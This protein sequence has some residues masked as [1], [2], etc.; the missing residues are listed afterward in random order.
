MESNGQAISKTG[1]R[2]VLNSELASHVEQRAAIISD[3]LEQL[4]EQGG[5]VAWKEMERRRA[6]IVSDNDLLVSQG[7]FNTA[8]GWQTLPPL[9]TTQAIHAP[10]FTLALQENLRRFEATQLCVANAD[11]V[12]AALAVG[13]AC[14]LNF[15]NETTPGGLYRRGA[16]A[17]EE[18]L[19]QQIPQLCSALEAVQHTAYPIE[20]GTA[21]LTLGLPVVRRGGTYELCASLGEVNIISAAMPCQDP[22]SDIAPD[23]ED[24]VTL[25]IR[26]VLRA[27]LRSGKPNLILGA[28]GCGMFGNPP[29]SVAKIFEQQLSSAEFRGAFGAVVFAILEPSSRDGPDPNFEAFAAM[30]EALARREDEGRA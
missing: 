1:H 23:W 3:E 26:S 19:C 24:T 10:D 8:D 20:P 28:F 4:F 13:D 12:S 27:G 6:R 15:A 22:A 17:Q 18:A 16:K 7:G 2:F 11:T 29:G 9:P 21:L 14:A 5:P 30:V 25:R